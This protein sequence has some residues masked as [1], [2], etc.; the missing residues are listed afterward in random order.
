M[1]LPYIYIRDKP[2]GHGL[3]NRIEGLDAEYTINDQKLSLRYCIGFSIYPDHGERE[4]RPQQH[5]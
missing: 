2:K 3:K 4:Q 5:T 1:S